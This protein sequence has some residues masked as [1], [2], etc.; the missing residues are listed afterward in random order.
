L[1]DQTFVDTRAQ[2][3]R[4]WT[5]AVSLLL[6]TGLV[7]LGFLAPLMRVAVLE[8]P[9]N[10][11]MWLPPQ[12]PT[13]RPPEP[14]VKP[15]P[16]Q[17]IHRPV[18]HLIRLQAPSG[19]PRYIDTTPDAPEIGSAI[20]GPQ[21]AEFYAWVSGTAI[22]LAPPAALPV[23]P[24]PVRPSV[25]VRIANGVQSAKLVFGPRPAYP[26]LARATRVQGTVKI[27][28][29]IGRDGA[30]KDLQV[31]SGPPLLIAV[32]IE[33][34]RQWRYL[35]TLLNGDAVEVVTDIDVNFTIGR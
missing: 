1:F 32:A 26:P 27:Q 12:A 6:Q 9:E 34:V 11:S 18:F 15:V 3:R 16:R 4:P 22:E 30:I 13:Q 31:I 5:V 2:T 21:S 25:P 10:V 33:A 8:R 20:P 19:V 35:P 23:S 14:E 29:V 17:E 24:Q 7:A 28:A